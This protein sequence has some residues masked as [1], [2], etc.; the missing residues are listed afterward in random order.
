VFLPKIDL[1]AI[2]ELESEGPIPKGEERILLVDDEPLLLEAVGQMLKRLGY[3][4]VTKTSSIEACETFLAQPEAFDLVITDM[5]MPHMTGVELAQKLLTLRPD[6]PIIL[7]SGFSE[8]I[9]DKQAKAIGI[10]EFVMKPVL[11]R[12]IAETIRR[13]LNQGIDD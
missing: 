1:E 5:T 11:L 13:A 3:D 7:C 6:I 2:E 9:T 10:K 4:L 12:D 8:I